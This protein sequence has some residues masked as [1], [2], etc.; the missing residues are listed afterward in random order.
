MWLC[1]IASSQSASTHKP[2]SSPVST[3]CGCWPAPCLGASCRP[4]I[5]CAAA[6]HERPLP[7]WQQAHQV[8]PGDYL[9]VQAYRPWPLPRLANGEQLS[10]TGFA[11]AERAVVALL[12]GAAGL[13]CTKAMALGRCRYLVARDPG[14]DND[15][16]AP[17]KSKLAAAR[18][19]GIAVVNLRWLLD[20][21]E[22]GALQDPR[23]PGA[24]SPPPPACHPLGT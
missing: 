8:K 11:G 5:R 1:S 17:G 6:G 14:A 20:S 24:P 21:L 7:P 9:P 16:A 12:A 23:E 3:R 4:A 19:R 22:R 13:A 15:A 10:L 18:K 2:F